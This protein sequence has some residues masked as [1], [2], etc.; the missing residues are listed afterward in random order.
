MTCVCWQSLHLLFLVILLREC[1]YKFPKFFILQKLAFYFQT[2]EINF[3][4][5]FEVLASENAI[6]VRICS[7][8]PIFSKNQSYGVFERV[9]HEFDIIFT[10][11][12]MLAKK[13]SI[14]PRIKIQNLLKA[15]YVI[16]ADF[17]INFRLD[18]MQYAILFLP[19]AENLFAPWLIDK[20]PIG[21]HFF[22]LL[23]SL[24][25]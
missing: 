6:C 2:S 15:R 14:F 5:F 16:H 9:F 10:F 11:C 8:Y 18:K 13:L 23:S 24:Y 21:R 1:N 7:I 19:Y 25:W 20:S 3:Y 12:A 4:N 17:S 22:P